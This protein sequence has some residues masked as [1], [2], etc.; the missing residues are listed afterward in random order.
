MSWIKNKR[1][2]I[3]SYLPALFLEKGW[4]KVTMYLT[5][6]NLG[7]LVCVIPS[8]RKLYSTSIRTVKITHRLKK[9]QIGY[10]HCFALGIVAICARHV[11]MLKIYETLVASVKCMWVV[12]YELLLYTPIY[13][14]GECDHLNWVGKIMLMSRMWDNFLILENV[15]GYKV[16]Q[17][18]S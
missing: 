11:S 12:L 1:K 18:R 3:Q 15:E 13:S 14:A 4:T 8:L 5:F 10:E 9:M 6:D 16:I 7:H 17:Q 2:N